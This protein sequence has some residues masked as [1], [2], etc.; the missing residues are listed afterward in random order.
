MAPFVLY[1]YQVVTQTNIYITLFG[2]FTMRSA[3]G[4]LLIILAL[5]FTLSLATSGNCNWWA[6]DD[7]EEFQLL[8]FDSASAHELDQGV[9]GYYT[10]SQQQIIVL[11]FNQ[12]MV[13]QPPFTWSI[14]YWI[15]STR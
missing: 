10:D 3:K 8:R 15:P 1:C 11:D 6:E 14:V 13:I 5:I 9:Y 7:D 2:G 12:T 4:S